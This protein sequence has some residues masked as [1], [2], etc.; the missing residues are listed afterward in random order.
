MPQVEPGCLYDP[1]GRHNAR[2]DRAIRLLATRADLLAT[3]AAAVQAYAA[4]LDP[5]NEFDQL[6]VQGVALIEK[7]LASLEPR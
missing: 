5:G 6:K 7:G 1:V 2:S 4:T 3:I